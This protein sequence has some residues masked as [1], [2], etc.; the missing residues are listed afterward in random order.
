MA[1]LYLIKLKVLEDILRTSILQ[2]SQLIRGS[3]SCIHDEHKRCS[4]DFL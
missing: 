1:H 2:I 3:I 4:K